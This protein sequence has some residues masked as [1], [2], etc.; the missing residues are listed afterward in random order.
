MAF[1]VMAYTVVACIVMANIVVAYIVMACIVMAYIVMAV[2]TLPFAGL[3]VSNKERRTGRDEFVP[4]LNHDT[5][6]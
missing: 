5:A 2:P 1:M 6:Y 3:V 4:S